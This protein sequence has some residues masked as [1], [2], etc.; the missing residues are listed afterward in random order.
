MGDFVQRNIL[1]INT[2]KRIP[3]GVYNDF[4]DYILAQ[5]KSPIQQIHPPHIP[6][7]ATP[8]KL[9]KTLKD[10]QNVW[11]LIAI[12]DINLKCIDFFGDQSVDM[13]YHYIIDLGVGLYCKADESINELMEG[14]EGENEEK[15]ERDERDGDVVSGMSDNEQAFICKKKGNQFY[16]QKKYREAIV[17]YKKAQSLD[18]KEPA[19][20]LN[21]SAA[22][23]MMEEWNDTLL[24]C[25]KAIGVAREHSDDPEW[26]FKAFRRMGDVAE[27]QG[28]QRQAIEYYKKA[29]L[30]MDD[31]M[32]KGK[33]KKLKKIKLK[34]NEKNQ[35]LWPMDQRYT[36]WSEHKMIEYLKMVGMGRYVNIFKL[37]GLSGKNFGTLIDV[38][39]LRNVIQMTMED[40]VQLSS[41][42][43]HR[44]DCFKA[45]HKSNV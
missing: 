23:F 12:F 24:C 26:C 29:L 3:T 40:A 11:L 2:A 15:Q 10:G 21:E 34:K 18:K 35:D 7:I 8:L 13:K 22:L 37:Y 14:Q 25:A 43:T 41:I 39:Y 32:L 1:G 17:E 30:E 45:M 4:C 44:K 5:I 33:I 42:L 31:D 19:Y 28:S 9:E 16:L 38:N 20:L 6:K 27:K 36:K